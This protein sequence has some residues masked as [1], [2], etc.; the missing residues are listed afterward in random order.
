M[1]R[2]S[3]DPLVRFVRQ[4]A[5]TKESACAADGELLERFIQRRD[6][7]AF[8]M[9]VRRHGPMVLRLY[10]RILHREP[11]AEDA[12]QATFLVFSRQAASL[13]P[14][15]SLGGWLY[16]VAYRI[17]QKARVAAARRH[18]YE[19]R[20]AG[21]QVDDPLAQ[22][23]VRE[24]H[25]ILD[26]ELARLPDK[27]RIPLVLCYLEGLTRDEAAQQL[28][29]PAHTLKTRLEQARE[30]LRGRL[31][32]RGLAP[33]AALLA[34]LLAGGSASGAVPAV[35]FDSTI[36]AAICVAAG[37]TAASVVSAQVAGLTEGVLQAMFLK[38]LAVAVLPLATVCLG[39][40]VLL[41]RT[42]AQDP[43]PDV[44]GPKQA[45]TQGGSQ[46]VPKPT[47]PG[48]LL[49]SRESGVVTLDPEGKQVDELTPPKGTRSSPQ[50]GGRLSPD[51]QRAAFIVNGSGPRGP[52][53]PDDPDFKAPWPFKVVIRKLGKGKAEDK[54]VGFPGVYLF[55]CWH[56]DGKRLLV[57]K[58]NDPPD[59]SVLLDPDTGKTEP[60]ELPA[61]ALVLDWSRDGKRLIVYHKDNRLRLGLLQEG[62][63]EPREL[64]EL[65]ARY[66]YSIAARLS[67]DGKKVLFTDADPEKKDAYKWGWS[68]QPH[69]LDIATKKRQPLADFP[70]NARVFSVAWSPDGK[71]LA[72]TWDQ[73][74][75]EILKKD[76]KDGLGE[77]PP[78]EAFLI[79]ADADGRN[80]KTV[81]SGKWTL[82]PIFTSIDWR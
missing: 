62:T 50:F 2:S 26:R 54:V 68:S 53:D 81:A 66:L 42:L 29:W 34:T 58:R 63:N 1:T 67:P 9:L 16:K 44:K 21:R 25:A 43:Q 10:R 7:A 80:A 79:V 40:G 72:Y 69:V 3:S 20:A 23:S 51:G 76:P 82:N 78:T 35:L 31:A 14:T 37:H 61:G 77:I 60:V 18:K 45:Q 56:G 33:S 6:Q 55:L 15:E 73:L 5:A 22:I 13:R 4:V 24:A 12:F 38:N 74:H 70:D 64:T 39:A 27:F 30:R 48:T 17:A 65:K 36:E 59:S 52:L 8:A 28:G 71:R 46:P 41:C 57:T 32:A 47:G 75:P 49:L 11:D 19:S